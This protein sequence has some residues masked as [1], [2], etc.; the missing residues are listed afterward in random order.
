MSSKEFKKTVKVDW[1]PEYG[2]IIDSL[3]IELNAKA[4]DAIIEAAEFLKRGENPFDFDRVALGL[5]YLS[6]VTPLIQDETGKLIVDE[7]HNGEHT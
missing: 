1:S 6:D 4:I 7:K 2:A 5:R 3:Q